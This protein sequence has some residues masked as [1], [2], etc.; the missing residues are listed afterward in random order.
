[1]LIREVNILSNL[2]CKDDNKLITL[3]TNPAGHTDKLHKADLIIR[4]SIRKKDIISELDSGCISACTFIG[5]ARSFINQNMLRRSKRTDS[6][7]MHPKRMV[8]QM[9]RNLHSSLPEC[10]FD[11]CRPTRETP[12]EWRFT[13]GPIV[14]FSCVHTE[15]MFVLVDQL[16]IR[17]DVELVPFF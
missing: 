14:V 5:A 16:T 9:N 4:H 1:M 12:L 17:T 11:H 6:P 15:K 7:T 8:R 2:L 3:S 13:C 10:N